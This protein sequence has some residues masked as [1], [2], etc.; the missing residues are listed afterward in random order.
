M[1]ADM[2]GHAVGGGRLDL[3]DVQTSQKTIRLLPSGDMGRARNPGS[4]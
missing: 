1:N 4:V 2:H 3:S